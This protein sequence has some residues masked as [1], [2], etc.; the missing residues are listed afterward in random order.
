MELIFHN[1]CIHASAVSETSPLLNVRIT[2]NDLQELFSSVATL[3]TTD[4]ILIFI[5]R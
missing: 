2:V 5:H 4:G 1:N 3:Q